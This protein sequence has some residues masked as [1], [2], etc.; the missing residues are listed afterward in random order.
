MPV[1]QMSTQIG[2][3]TATE[4]DGTSQQVSGETA[5]R[6]NDP[7]PPK[8]ALICPIVGATLSIL[9]RSPTSKQRLYHIRSKGLAMRGRS[10]MKYPTHKGHHISIT[11]FL[12][13]NSLQL[14]HP[15]FH[16]PVTIYPM[17]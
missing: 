9:M 3:T 1:T 11:R 6:Q 10:P 7:F 17:R 12:N 8:V 5:E 15:F 16:I 14:V 4:M 13:I 2:I